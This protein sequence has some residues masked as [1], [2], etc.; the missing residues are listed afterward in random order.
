MARKKED[1]LDL[2][3]VLNTETE[4][5]N[6]V[7]DAK[8]IRDSVLQELG[9][10]FLQNQKPVEKE[11]V[12][13]VN[14]VP[15]KP[16]RII[17]EIKGASADTAMYDGKY[18]PGKAMGLAG[19][20][21]ISRPVNRNMTS[22]KENTNYVTGLNVDEIAANPNLTEDVKAQR[23]KDVQIARKW[24]EWKYK[25]SLASNNYKFWDDYKIVIDDLSAVYDTNKMTS[26]KK[27]DPVLLYFTILGGA[28]PDIAPSFDELGSR[29]YYM[30]VREEEVQRNFK[31]QKDKI[32]AN[33]VLNEVMSNWSKQDMLFLINYLED[34]EYGFTLNTPVDLL[35]QQLSD[36]LEGVDVKT[37][38][39]K[40]PT[41]FLEAVALFKDSPDAV[42]ARALFNA[43]LYYGFIVTDSTRQF[44]NRTTDFIY[45]SSI[46]D[47]VD[48][49]L[50]PRYMDE[51]TYIQSK[52]IN[53]WKV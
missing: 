28:H 33:A 34:K 43:A 20:K 24:L 23:I 31:T 18:I 11:I 10:Q 13:D 37:E 22:H 26:D 4:V 3:N 2:D 8:S 50:N 27:E 1:V 40:Q 48:K 45:G 6:P 5:E 9:V 32:K 39:R 15:D 25:S 53:K 52:V 16:R 14:V 51:R 29:V 42:K 41:K 7:V 46:Q 49:L 44:V 30:T 35:I 47:A 19:S 36:F 38:K 12:N 21:L 17:F